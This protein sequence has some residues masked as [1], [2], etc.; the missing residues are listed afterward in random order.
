MIVVGLVAVV[1][2]VAFS[3]WQILDD[4]PAVDPTEEVVDPGGVTI[5]REPTSS[6]RGCTYVRGNPDIR[7]ASA[8][9]V[10]TF[11]QP[12]REE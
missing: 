2:L 6:R 7:E 11:A 8:R 9:G 1:V 4:E 10:P 12:R 5:P 3:L